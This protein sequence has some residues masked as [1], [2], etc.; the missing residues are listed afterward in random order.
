MT[1][2]SASI[3]KISDL[4]ASDKDVMYHLYDT[5]YAGGNM[6][7]FNKDLDSKNYA[8]LL[9]DSGGAIRGF[10]T[11]AVYDERYNNSP[12]RVVYSGDTIIDKAYWGK[13]EFATVWLRFVGHLKAQVP[14]VPLYWLLIVKGH[15]TYRYLSIFSNEYYPRHDLETPAEYQQLMHYLASGRFGNAYDPASGLVDFPEPR[16]FLREDLVPI[17]P[18]D[19]SRP[20]VKFFLSK[21]PGYTKGDELLC[22]CELQ[23]DTLTRFARGWFLEG[24]RGEL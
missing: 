17:P 18:K 16:S 13:N 14:D 9:K 19:Q 5:Y 12:L 24:M 1:W 21:N 22:L 8:V 7:V 20:D 3:H 4:S 6:S 2:L 10:S 11:L 23:P 15:R